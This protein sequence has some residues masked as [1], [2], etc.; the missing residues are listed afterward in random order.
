M[1]ENN[2]EI[3][4]S[5]QSEA[6]PFDPSNTERIAELNAKFESAD[7]FTEVKSANSLEE[8][9]SILSTAKRYDWSEGGSNRTV[10]AEELKSILE[11]VSQLVKS[12]ADEAAIL[13]VEDKIPDMGLLSKVRS[14]RANKAWMKKAGDDPWLNL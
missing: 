14:V 7:A 2:Q 9:I 8:M 12:G 3:P 1:L 4:I 5:A 11:E 10:D 13:A 6:Q